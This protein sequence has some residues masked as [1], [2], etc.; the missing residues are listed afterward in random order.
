MVVVGVAPEVVSECDVEV[1][2]ED[3][4]TL[5]G[6]MHRLVEGLVK[7]SMTLE[8]ILLF[9]A[10]HTYATNLTVSSQVVPRP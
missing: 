1:S 5:A 2:Y 8:G 9:S 6:V 3:L 4:A 7:Q 10:S